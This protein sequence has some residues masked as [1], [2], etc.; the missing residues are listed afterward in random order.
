MGMGSSERNLEAEIEAIQKQGALRNPTTSERKKPSNSMINGLPPN[1]TKED[2][3]QLN[4]RAYSEVLTQPIDAHGNHVLFY[5]AHYENDEVLTH[6]INQTR[7][8]GYFAEYITSTNQRG[9][10]VL[11]FCIRSSNAGFRSRLD[12]FYKEGRET[13]QEMEQQPNAQKKAEDRLWSQFQNSLLLSQHNPQHFEGCETMQEMETA[14][15]QEHPDAML[16]AQLIKDLMSMSV[17]PQYT[18]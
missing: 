8:I 4:R 5:V 12:A 10:T 3:I 18:P 11:D 7:R 9:S 17:P 13:M 14:K 1:P 16:V 6:L 2:Q 15:A